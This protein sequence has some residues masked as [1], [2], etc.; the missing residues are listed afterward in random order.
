V[1][2]AAVNAV[3]SGDPSNPVT[4]TPVAPAVD[5]LAV[6]FSK[7]KSGDLRM[8]GTGNIAGASLTFRSGSATGT[9]FADNVIVQP[10]AAGTIN[11]TWS[12]RVRAGS[13]ATRN[14]SPVFISSDK[15]GTLGPLTVPN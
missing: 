14:P 5:T 10:P 8:D 3:G 13:A 12:I 2:V 11:G 6:T 9:V 1:T 15:G 4:V 7:W